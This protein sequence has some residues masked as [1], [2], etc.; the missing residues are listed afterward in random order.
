MA[1]EE[2]GPIKRD[3]RPTV[4]RLWEDFTVPHL[5][6]A[7]IDAMEALPPDQLTV[8]ARFIRPPFVFEQVAGSVLGGRF[9]ILGVRRGD[10]KWL[11]VRFVGPV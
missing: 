11:L 2:Y 9:R 3:I 4:W 1:D 7:V 8:E 6:D 5:P 10:G